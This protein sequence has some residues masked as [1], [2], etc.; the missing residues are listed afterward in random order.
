MVC[1]KTF[2]MKE[3]IP[4]NTKN[5]PL[6]T[7]PKANVSLLVC[8]YVCVYLCLCACVC[9]CVSGQVYLSSIFWDSSTFIVGMTCSANILWKTFFSWFH[10]YHILPLKQKKTVHLTLYDPDII[11]PVISHVI[12]KSFSKQ[13]TWIVFFTDNGGNQAWCKRIS[14]W[15]MGF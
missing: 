6:K 4:C 11:A 1:I 5:R 12:Y 15:Q 7:T 9:L 8:V 3:S 10:F 13:R 2:L 14:T